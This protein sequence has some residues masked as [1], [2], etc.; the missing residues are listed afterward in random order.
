[1]KTKKEAVKALMKKGWITPAMA[2]TKVGC[3]SLSQ[4]VGELIRDGEKVD[5]G[6]YVTGSGVR[7]RKYRL[8]RTQWIA[9]ELK[10][11]RG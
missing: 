9:S 8:A 11:V 10:V 2:F 6:W 4:R 5:K 7:V 1:M 3:L